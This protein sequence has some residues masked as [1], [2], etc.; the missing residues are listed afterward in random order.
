MKKTT[1]AT[2]LISAVCIALGGVLMGAGAAAGGREQI[3]SGDFRLVHV[4]DVEHLLERATEKEVLDFGGT[5]TWK[6]QDREDG[7]EVLNGDFVRTVASGSMPLNVKVTL[8]IHS[9]I[10]E[11]S[12][13]NA[14]VLEGENCDRIQCYVK[15]DTLYIKDVGKEKKYRHIN[16][17]TL[18]LL[19]P[20]GI[21]W[22]KA[23]INADLGTINIDRLEADKAE[24][25]ADL[26][27]I[28]IDD[29]YADRLEAD[30]DLGSIEI[31]DGSADSA[32]FSAEMGSI[33]YTGVLEGDVEAEA[34]MGSI[35]MNLYQTESD[36]DFEIEVGMGSIT[37]D[38]TESSY[39]Y[40]G[41]DK[42]KKISNGAGRKMK[43]TSSMGSIVI[44]F[45]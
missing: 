33:Q 40:S 7:Q 9:L 22:D 41:M 25:D 44:C 26:G 28:V 39:S 29:L 4:E 17:R 15:K 21:S 2:V 12:S 24:L 37:L 42:E 11:E 34:D 43:L 18:R 10:I 36:F 38:G 20:E 35:E 6:G 30:A 14:I 5:G 16:D 31:R 23:E 27:Q 19:V 13:E 3:A 45:E 8:G 32:D 1:Q